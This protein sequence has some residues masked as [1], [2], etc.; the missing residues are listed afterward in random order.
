MCAVQSDDNNVSAAA[1]EGE[2]DMKSLRSNS[3]RSDSGLSHLFWAETETSPNGRWR[4]RVIRVGAAEVAEKSTLWG[5]GT[6]GRAENSERN[7]RGT[8]DG[9]SMG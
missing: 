5:L 7:R 3:E 2:E 1:V 9:D 8:H 6:F 4:N